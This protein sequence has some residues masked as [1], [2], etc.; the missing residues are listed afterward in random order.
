MK[1]TDGGTQPKYRTRIKRLVG[2][3]EKTTATVIRFQ[4]EWTNSKFFLINGTEFCQKVKK[5]K[6]EI[7]LLFH[8]KRIVLKS[9]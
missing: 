2:W 1:K 6:S 8:L 7:L 5:Q 4:Q 3:K 9:I